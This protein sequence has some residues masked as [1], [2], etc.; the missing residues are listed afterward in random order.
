MSAEVATEVAPT[1]EQRQ[2]VVDAALAATVATG[3]R[4]CVVFGAADV[5]YAEPDG[6]AWRSDEPP[7]GGISV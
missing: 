2:A 1:D 5:V 7:T 6:S 3:L 4:R